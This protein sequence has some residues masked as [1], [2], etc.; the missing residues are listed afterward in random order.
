MASGA[1]DVVRGITQAE[2]KN[3]K[4]GYITAL[5]FLTAVNTSSWAPGTKLYADTSGNITSTPTGL[6]LAMVMKQDAVN[7]VVYIE[8]T[9][10]TKGDL[11]SLTFPDA[12]S[13]ELAWSISYPEFYT[14]VVY[15]IN[16]IVQDVNTY[17]SSSK[18]LHIFNKHYTYSSGLPTKIEITR[19]YDGQKITKDIVYDINGYILNV[20][21]TYTV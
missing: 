9:G 4:T 3:G 2:I 15:D 6:P 20:T 16:N 11:D 12:L 14:E 13:M 8:N 18:T 1:V 7:G 19:V 21:R 10:V 17:D 5:G